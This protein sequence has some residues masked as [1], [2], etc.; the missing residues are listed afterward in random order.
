[1]RNSTSRFSLY[2]LVLTAVGAAW[3][4]PAIGQSTGPDGFLSANAIAQSYFQ[5]RLFEFVSPIYRQPLISSSLIES[6]S[7]PGPDASP[8]Q[9]LAADRIAF[10]GASAVQVESQA[11]TLELAMRQQMMQRNG[12]TVGGVR[13]TTQAAGAAAQALSFQARAQLLKD[14][15]EYQSEK[16]RVRLKMRKEQL[17]YVLA[18]I[19]SQSVNGSTAKSGQMINILLDSI[20]P[21]LLE[22]SYGVGATAT[23]SKEIKA[24]TM[25][26]EDIAKIQLQI[27]AEG[28]PVIFT[29]DKATIDMGRVPFVLNHPKLTPLVRDIETRIEQLADMVQG[30]E[31]YIKTIELGQAVQKLDTECD[32]VLGTASE[33]GQRG[34]KDYRLWNLGKDYRTRIKGIVNRLELEGSPKFLK[35]AGKKYD[36]KVN[37]DGVLGFA[38][39]IAENG[40]KV[41]PAAQGEEAVYSRF[42][43]LLMQL[44]AIVSN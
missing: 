3:S 38:R 22:Y 15:L 9:K 31:F 6:L 12:Y 1:M 2:V 11:M 4:S 37:G 35:F 30:A 18:K 28:P 24:L 41:A 7:R 16:N 23:F 32:R 40:C 42:C 13:S 10:A 33:N 20:K 39:F 21:S 34:Q 14:Q 29:A 8:S 27:E 26:P 25:R 44:Q 43:L 5:R 36:P 19:K 17:E